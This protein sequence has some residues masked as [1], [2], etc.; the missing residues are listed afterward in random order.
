MKKVNASIITIGDELLIGQTIDTNSAFIAQE[1]N[2]IGVWVRHRTAV[3]DVWDD[4][5]NALDDESKLSDIIIITG[6]LGP[7]ADDITKPLLCKYFGG[8]LIVDEKVENHV[9]YLFEKVFRRPGPM[10]ERN[11]KQAEVPDVCTVLFNKRGTAPGMLFRKDGKIFISLPGVP[12]EMK[13]LI[14]TEVIPLI[15]N[16]F[17]LPAIV[18]K[19]AFTAGMG[20]SMIAERLVDLEASLPDT[21]KLAYLPNYGMVRLR[22]TITADTNEIAEDQVIPFFEQLKEKVKDILVS[23][24]DEGLEVVI[25]KILK[26]KNKT[27]ATAESCTGG[28]IAHLITSVPGSSAY[29]NGS[30]VS[31]SNSVKENVL[32]VSAS[33]LN[34]V[35]AVSEETVTEMVKG[36]I[37]KLDVDYAVAVSG[38]MGPDGGTPEKPVGLVWVA[39]GN[40]E[41]TETTKLQFRFD[42]HRNIEMTAQNALNILRKFI[43]E[44]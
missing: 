38:I 41:K 44:N 8:K 21:I 30:V 20:E 32:G 15:Q 6:G 22:L 37:K 39:I 17:S 25:G 26:E 27:I 14:T 18:H 28:Y 24:I 1:L 7:T 16:E 11:L 29:F 40:K 4:I 36:V 3:G 31:Y 13:G 35:G 9:R 12:H 19:T 42:R 23:D 2:K 10:L 5:W 43:L 34:T 33:T